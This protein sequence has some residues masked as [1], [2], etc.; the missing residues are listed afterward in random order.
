MC[1]VTPSTGAESDKT[2]PPGAPVRS[3]SAAPLLPSLLRGKAVRPHGPA[4]P[5]SGG[6]PARPTRDDP[7]RPCLTRALSGASA[8]RFSEAPNLASRGRSGGRAP[9]G[10]GRPVS[11]AQ[12]PR[13]DPAAPRRRRGR[14]PSRRDTRG[15]P[16][17]RRR[18]RAGALTVCGA[19]SVAAPAS[20]AGGK[21]PPARR[22]P[23]PRPLPSTRP[24]GPERRRPPLR[25]LGAPPPPTQWPSPQPPSRAPAQRAQRRARRLPRF[26]Q[27]GWEA[28]APALSRRV[29]SPRRAPASPPPVVASVTSSS[30][31]Q[32]P[33]PGTEEPV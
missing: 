17:A 27:A 19:V 3:A 8:E 13:V 20:S 7:G 30:W 11:R 24:S 9:R 21:W 23:A 26:A 14:A 2:P 28:G 18:P 29:P 15:G 6:K 10:T 4:H 22:A 16:A 31:Q 32:A 33:Q 12:G 25:D 5:L 1:K